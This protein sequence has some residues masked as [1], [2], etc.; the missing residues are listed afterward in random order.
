MLLLIHVDGA[1]WLADVGFGVEGL[2]M[3]VPFGSGK[4]VRQFA[5]S[6]RVIEEEGQWVLQS[7]RNDSWVDLYAFTLEPQQLADYELANYY[8]STHPDSRFV[9]TLIV[10]LPRQEVR[11]VLRNREL[12]LDRGANMVTR[13]MLADDEELLDV[14]AGTFDLRF[15]PGTGFRLRDTTV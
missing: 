6:Y 7:L 4:M 8:T 12:I 2:L 10:Q 5:W 15:P 11:R 9:P 13:R 14:L 3:P 1:N